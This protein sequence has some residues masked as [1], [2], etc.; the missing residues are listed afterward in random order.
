MVGLHHQINGHEF[1]QAPGDGERQETLVCRS[2]WGHKGS[3]MTGRLNRNKNKLARLLIHLKKL[4]NKNVTIA[5]TMG[6]QA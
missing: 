4:R 3:D 5:K 1:E 6:S 2:P